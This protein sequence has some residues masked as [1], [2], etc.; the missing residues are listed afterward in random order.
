MKKIVAAFAVLF[1]CVAFSQ[2]LAASATGTATATVLKPLTV[3]QLQAMDL[4]FISPPDVPTTITM[5][6]TGFVSAGASLVHGTTKAGIFEING[7]ASR[8]VI[9]SVDPTFTL[10]GPASTSITATTSTTLPPD[11][12]LTLGGGGTGVVS[13]GVSF[14]MPPT[15]APGA[16]SGT[17]AV[18][19][20]YQ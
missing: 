1:A 10:S 8:I 9:V 3:A 11:N 15:A 12:T 2:A 13:V 16:Y 5:T 17:Y 6:P 4:A 20:V 14:T 7:S 19:A 18:A